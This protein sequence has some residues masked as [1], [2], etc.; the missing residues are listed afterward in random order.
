MKGDFPVNMIM[1]TVFFAVAIGSILA[2]QNTYYSDFAGV[3]KIPIENLEVVESAHAVESC[4]ARLSANERFISRDVLEEYAG[5]SIN[6]ICEI[7]EPVMWAYVEDI[8]GDEKGNKIGYLFPPPQSDDLVKKLFPPAMV[9]EDFLRKIREWRN[10]DIKTEHMIWVSIAVPG[11]KKITDENF[12]LTG[13]FLIQATWEGLGS[14]VKNDVILKLYPKDYYKTFPA[15]IQNIEYYEVRQWLED[16]EKNGIKFDSRIANFYH[17]PVRDII[18]S[19]LV[20]CGKMNILDSLKSETCVELFEKIN[21]THMG[22]L[23]VKI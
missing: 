11:V 18:P 20:E 22:R 2:M 1:G 8:E 17:I 10:K 23:G 9:T 16:M 7:Q 12:W 4:L 21:E 5:D 19:D 6:R 14:P 13:E 3:M 15:N